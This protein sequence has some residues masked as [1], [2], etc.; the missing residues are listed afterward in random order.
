[1]SKEFAGRTYVVTGAA[2]GIGLA[3]VKRLLN[4]GA[5]VHACDID[6]INP[7][8]MVTGLNFH[9]I[10]V[11]DE[12]SVAKLFYSLKQSGE[13]INGLVNN[14]AILDSTQFD[15]LNSERIKEVLEIN[16]GGTL[17]FTRYAVPLLEA[18]VSAY[19]PM[20]PHCHHRPDLAN[21]R[22]LECM[23]ATNCFSYLSWILDIILIN[24]KYSLRVN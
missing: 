16:L 5:R 2:R 10:D 7:N 9:L 17:N 4:E 8:N 21:R 14:A 13:K 24:L 12:E 22:R 6:A 20:M 15:E 1:M 18:S 3:V 23:E 11:R 19:F